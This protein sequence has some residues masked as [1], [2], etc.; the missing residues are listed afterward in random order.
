MHSFVA[1][2]F[3]E[4]NQFA[5]A[6]LPYIRCKEARF[7]GQTLHSVP[8]FPCPCFVAEI[9]RGKAS[10]SHIVPKPFSSSLRVGQLTADLPVQGT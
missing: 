5:L 7:L 9:T 2:W 8:R 1:T 4:W 3:G 10:L 6:F